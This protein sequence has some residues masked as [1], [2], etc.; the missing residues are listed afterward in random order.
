MSAKH[1]M[2]GEN[3]SVYRVVQHILTTEAAKQKKRRNE[4]QS[5]PTRN[6]RSPRR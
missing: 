4:W 6:G 1:R 5:T 2:S 3:V